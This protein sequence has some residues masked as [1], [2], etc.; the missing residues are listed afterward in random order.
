[1]KDQFNLR[2]PEGMRDFV[3]SEAEKNNRSMN[4]EIIFQLKRIY[5][6]AET[7]KADARA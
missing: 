7:Q 4:A 2:L 3:R 5:R 1:M 6:M